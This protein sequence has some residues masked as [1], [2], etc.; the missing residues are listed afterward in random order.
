MFGRPCFESRPEH[1]V[2]GQIWISQ[3]VF[4]MANVYGRS[5]QGDCQVCANLCG[6]HSVCL[7]A[8]Q[9]KEELQDLGSNRNRCTFPSQNVTGVGNRSDFAPKFSADRKPTARLVVCTHPLVAQL[10][11]N[12]MLLT[13]RPIQMLH[14]DCNLCQLGLLVHSC[15]LLLYTPSYPCSL[16]VVCTCID[17]HPGR[18]IRPAK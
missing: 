4:C 5:R 11:M 18:C 12:L 1:A 7:A 9:C 10:H 14:S 17:Q 13:H 6:A 15:L 3:C 2:S 8:L 16:V